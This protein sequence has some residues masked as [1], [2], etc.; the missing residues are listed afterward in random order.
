LTVFTLSATALPAQDVDHGRALFQT[1]CATCHGADAAGN[2]PLAGALVLQPPN[3]T[4]LSA[5]NDGVFPLERVVNRI[6]GTDPLVSHGSPM[7]V[8]GPYFEGVANVGMKLQSG[9]P[10]MV[11]E[12]IAD[13]VGYLQ[14]VQTSE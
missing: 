4:T 3:L 11:S 6:D 10:I 8:F 13:L 2:G 12:P 5:E 7:P 9:Q 1:H 14:S